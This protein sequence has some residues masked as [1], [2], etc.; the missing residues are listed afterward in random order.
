M[1]TT[2][3]IESFIADGYVRV[4]RAFSLEAARQCRELLWKATG[5][6]PH[7]PSSWTRAVVRIGEMS[8]P[9]FRESANTPAL[10]EA[11]D[12]LVGPG[13]WI[14][15]QSLGTFP[16]R[17]PADTP[18]NDTGWHV[19]AGFP[20]NDA[21]NFMEWR[22]NVLSRGRGLLMLFLFSEVGHNDAPT[23]IRI[24]SHKDVANILFEHGDAGLSFMELAQAL[25]A[26]PGRE[27]ALATGAPGTVYLC[28][29]FV[30]HAA[31]D[32]HGT[33]PKFMAQPPLL[34]KHD[35]RISGDG[36]YPVEKAISD[37][38]NEKRSR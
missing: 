33:V 19:D 11:Y 25:A 27:E 28:H 23:R 38:L 37:A 36:L 29:P 35:F 12:Q 7:D 8:H 13:N 2:T 1:L 15:R 26:M 5:C 32:H 9:Q 18:A 20:G 31:Q 22:I 6:K 34:T 4:D 16:I 10:C 21:L 14:P 30:A 3:Q 24:G 17:F